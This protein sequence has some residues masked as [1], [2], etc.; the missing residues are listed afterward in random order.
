MP[1]A[2]RRLSGRGTDIY[3]S[4]ATPCDRRIRPPR[5]RS[6][7]GEGYAAREAASAC[8]RSQSRTEGSSQR[9]IASS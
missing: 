6:S 5:R 3:F 7:Y 9:P 1:A 8:W 2:C 4:G